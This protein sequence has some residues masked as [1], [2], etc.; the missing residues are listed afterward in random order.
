MKRGAGKQF[1]P[2]LV[3]VFLS[4]VKITPSLSQERR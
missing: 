3:E 4:I 2:K 1:D